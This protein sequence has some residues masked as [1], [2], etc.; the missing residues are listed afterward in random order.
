MMKEVQNTPSEVSADY[1]EVMVD[2]PDGITYSMTPDA[3][4]RTSARLLTEAARARA[5]GRQRFD[6]DAKAR[7]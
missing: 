6:G 3:A 7:H 2:G 4:T 1:G 5:Q